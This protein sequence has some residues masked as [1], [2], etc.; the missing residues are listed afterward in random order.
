MVKTNATPDLAGAARWKLIHYDHQLCVADTDLQED[1]AAFRAWRTL[2]SEEV[3]KSECWVESLLLVATKAATKTEDQAAR[4][5]TRRFA[6]WI[7]DGPANGLKRQRL[8]LDVPLDGLRTKRT[9]KSTP[10]FLS[11]MILRACLRS[12]LGQHWYRRT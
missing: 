4:A 5:A 11:L 3:L 9:T 2:C 10:T 1:A 8:F 6:D 12:N 7:A